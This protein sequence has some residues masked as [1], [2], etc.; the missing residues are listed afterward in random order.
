MKSR[1]DAVGLVLAR[2]ARMLGL[3]PFFME[4]IAGI[5][6]VLASDGRSL[7][8]H[9]VPDHDAEIAA[10]RRWGKGE[11]VDAVVVVNVVAEDPRLPILTELGIPAV[12]IGGPTRDLPFSNVWIDNA[13]AMR[14]AVAHLVS[15]GH[16]HLARVSGPS[17]LAHTQTR[18]EAFLSE[19]T[20][21]GAEGTVVE[22][23]Y[24][25]LSGTR[26]TRALLGRRGAPSAIVYDNDVMA[27]AG[28]G[29]AQEMG[30]PVPDQLSILAWD[31]SALC[32]LAH[33][34]LS[35]MSL[36][37]YA[38]GAQAADCVLNLLAGGPV[39]SHTAP[40]PRL[41]ARGSTASFTR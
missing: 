10:Y 13:Q 32:R 8:L 30:V 26:S 37:V 40:L 21:R 6:E 16:L 9:V 3:E 27:L 23:D 24:T 14:D 15:L 20:R 12:V 28:L 39:A 19:C 31:D 7:L 4:L 25:E 38:M 22:G 1:A 17:T 36:D 2:P 33:P 11:M 5:E 41:V 29:V 34:P 18:T 35:A